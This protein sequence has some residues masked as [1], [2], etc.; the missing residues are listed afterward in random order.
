MTNVLVIPENHLYK[1]WMVLFWTEPFLNFWIFIKKYPC[2]KNKIY[3]NCFD[4][5]ENSEYFFK[6]FQKNAKVWVVLAHLKPK[7]WR[8]T[9]FWGLCPPNYFSAAT[10]LCY[11]HLF[12]YVILLFYWVYFTSFFDHYIEQNMLL[13]IKKLPLGDLLQNSCSKS[14]LN[15]LK[16]AGES[17]L[18]LLKL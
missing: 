11:S 2:N 10:S 8:P 5:Q 4:K 9:F 16:Y 1:I 13:L 3:K 18:L 7:I 14:E 12:I 17:V 6:K 15:Q